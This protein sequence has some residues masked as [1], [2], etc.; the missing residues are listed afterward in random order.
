MG[1]HIGVRNSYLDY[2]LITSRPW[3]PSRKKSI[4]AYR[5]V[6]IP[7]IRGASKK[8]TPFQIQI[9]HNHLNIRCSAVSW[10]ILCLTQT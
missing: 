3:I 10:P 9:S 6:P 5:N 7:Y 2:L 8:C 4:G 1:A